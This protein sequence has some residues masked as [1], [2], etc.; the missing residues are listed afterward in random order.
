MTSRRKPTPVPLCPPQIPLDQTAAVGS[1]RLIAWAM[2][3]PNNRF[4][5]CNNCDASS[6]NEHNGQHGLYNCIGSTWYIYVLLR[7]AH[8][9]TLPPRYTEVFNHFLFLPITQYWFSF[10][11]YIFINQVILLVKRLTPGCQVYSL[12]AN[13][14]SCSTFI[15]DFL[16]ILERTF[17]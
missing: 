3:R 2:A 17:Y 8:S 13:R 11:I 1:Q 6:A 4:S 9:S 10:T 5:I 16:S 7:G 15:F 12:P 14:P